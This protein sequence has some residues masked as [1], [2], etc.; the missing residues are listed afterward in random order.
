MRPLL[1]SDVEMDIACRE[2]A[3]LPLAVGSGILTKTVKLSGSHHL[4]VNAR[5]NL[6]CA[7]RCSSRRR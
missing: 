4:A 2:P 7:A 5:D 6:A 1:P 3:T